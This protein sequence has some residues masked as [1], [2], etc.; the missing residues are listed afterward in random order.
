V[1]VAGRNVV[2]V[3]VRAGLVVLTDASGSVRTESVLSPPPPKTATPAAITRTT[4]IGTAIF[5]HSG[6]ALTHAANPVDSG[7]RLMPR[8]PSP[9]GREIRVPER[10]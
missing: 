5:D 6:S 7:R 10:P 4:T 1:V 8:I 9:G 3:E 2:V